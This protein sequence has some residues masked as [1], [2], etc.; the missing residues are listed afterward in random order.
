MNYKTLNTVAILIFFMSIV[1]LGCKDSSETRVDS[2]TT[3]SF[4]VYPMVV[5]ENN[6]GINDYVEKDTHMAEVDASVSVAGYSP[7]ANLAGQ[8]EFIDTNGD[9]ICDH[10]QDGSHTWHGPGF[11]DE[12]GKGICDYYE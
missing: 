1:F 10:A 7:A 3:R 5:D 4:D 11:V 9:G 6:N 2:G 12:D 8:H